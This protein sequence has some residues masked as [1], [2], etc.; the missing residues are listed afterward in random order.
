MLGSTSTVAENVITEVAT[1]TGTWGTSNDGT[2]WATL[3]PIDGFARFVYKD[4]ENNGLT[5]VQCL[6]QDCIT[7]V[8]TTIAT[9]T[10][11]SIDF[12]TILIGSD[13][14]P[15]ISY[16]EYGSP[17]RLHL[18]AC[19]NESCSSNVNTILVTGS[20]YE[21]AVDKGT[22]GFLKLVYSEYTPDAN[23]YRSLRLL[24]CQNISC[25]SY[26]TS[27][28]ATT[29]NTSG[30]GFYPDIAIDTNDIAH[31]FYNKYTD[32]DGSMYM[33]TCTNASCSSFSTNTIEIGTG[34]YGAALRVGNDNLPKVAWEANV[35]GAKVLRYANCLDTLCSSTTIT[36]LDSIINYHNLSMSL[37]SSNLARIAYGNERN[38]SYIQCLNGSCSS[39]NTKLIT[40]QGT[41]WVGLS[42]P[43][44]ITT[45]RIFFATIDY[46]TIKMARLIADD[47]RPTV[48]GSTIGSL[49]KSL[50]ELF[51]SRVKT[52]LLEVTGDTTMG[53]NLYVAGDTT[54]I[55]DLKA[56]GTTTLESTLLVAGP[57]HQGVGSA[58]NTDSYLHTNYWNHSSQSILN[59]GILVFGGPSGYVYGMDL[60]YSSQRATYSTRIFAPPS[61]DISFAK[62]T[63]STQPHTQSDFTEYMVIKSGGNIGIGT[64]TP[65]AKLSIKA[66]GQTTGKVV[67]ITDSNNAEKFT[68]LDNGKV[69]IGTTTPS[70]TLQ[71]GNTSISG[72]VARFQNS[73]GYCDINPTTTS[74]TCTSDLRLKK[75]IVT[76]DASTTLA[77]LTKL[78]PVTY[79]WLA[80]DNASSTHA[81]FIA[82]EVQPL[83][84]DL[85]STDENGTMSVAYSG[86]IPYIVEAMKGVVNTILS[87]KELFVTKNLCIGDEEDKTCITKAQLDTL[88]QA[89]KVTP[90]QNGTL[91]NTSGTV[92]GTSTVVVDVATSTETVQGDQV[93]AENGTT[94]PEIQVESQTEPQGAASST[95]EVFP[96]V[97]FTATLPTNP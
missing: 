43:T 14:L 18:I 4:N 16:V 41:A 76:L 22:D 9:S 5:F 93:T 19:L 56:R 61:A 52:A 69:G 90:S 32:S 44:S 96:E 38:I 54:V 12:P 95:G 84:P 58:S 35:N 53:G 87:F 78:N 72:V 29:T 75:N 66:S 49:L 3:S 94:T 36:T 24:V 20:F 57:I 60:G 47:G 34:W 17:D 82:Q 65:Q 50:G 79:N 77:T 46:M 83:F 81:G 64:T 86:F 63:N 30:N 67:S 45:P 80:E 25:S 73:T 26:S 70:Y 59:P 48:T 89:G 42:L 21:N 11:N 51:V 68:I 1:T 27:T 91:L 97:S 74:L 55:G 28:I 15:R 71:A 88:L 37:D 7:K 13:N 40:S 10:G 2:K 6:D 85:V 8:S 31:I 39:K 23:G 62:T 92:L 33:A